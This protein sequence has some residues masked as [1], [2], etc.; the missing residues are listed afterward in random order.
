MCD[1]ATEAENEVHF[2][3]KLNRRDVA[4]GAGAT[5]AALITG[6]PDPAASHQQGPSPSK[7]MTVTSKMVTVATPDGSAE[8]FF[9]APKQ[10]ARPGVIMW[11][12]VA[13]LRDTFKTMA[14]HLAEQGFAVLCVNPYYRSAKLPI[15]S[16]FADWQTEEGKAKIAPLR[17]ALTPEAVTRDAI[18]LTSFLDQQA[19]VDTTRKL[20]ALGYCMSGAFAIRAAAAKPS[21]LGLFA[22]FHGGGLVSQEP[23][24]PHLLLGQTKAAALICIAQ[25]DDARAPEDK[26]VLQKAAKQAGIPAEIEVYPAQHGWCVL[27]APVY[28]AAQAERAWA[29]LLVALGNL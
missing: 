10:G 17:A 21:R 8:A 14:T 19:E 15:L 1:D 25:N 13:G 22:S 12:D 27:D 29:R 28:D 11:P 4:L 18:A 16:R 23:S 20:A 7:S 3:S 2:R 6:C 5:L 26:V 9:V 24:S